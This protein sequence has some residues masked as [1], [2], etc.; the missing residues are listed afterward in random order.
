MSDIL[1]LPPDWIYFD[2]ICRKH[3]ISPDEVAATSGIDISVYEKW[4][5]LG[6]VP[7][8]LEIWCLL[9]NLNQLRGGFCV[10]SY[11]FTSPDED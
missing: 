6:V 4:K 9:N 8:K 1:Q 7:T 2:E 10:I 3:S 5:D 11:P